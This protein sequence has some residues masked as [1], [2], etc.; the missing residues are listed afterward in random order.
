MSTRVDL[1]LPPLDLYDDAHGGSDWTELMQAAGDIEAHLVSGRLEESGIETRRV[2]DRSG[3]A[4]LHGGSNP[5]APVTI[6]VRKTQ[7][8]DARIALAEV[9][10]EA[11]PARR[12]PVVM[13][14]R[15]ARRLLW[16]AA[17]LLLGLLFTGL[18][19]HATAEALAACFDRGECSVPTTSEER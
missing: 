2:K 8:E 12:E 1:P 14:S 3:P 17:A 9:A 4:W 13:T 18:G 11:A 19:L 7:Y 10:L 16:W 5:W 6:Y 15:S